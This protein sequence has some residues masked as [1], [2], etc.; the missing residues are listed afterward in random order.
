MKIYNFHYHLQLFTTQLNSFFKIRLIGYLFIAL[1][2]ALILG[3]TQKTYGHEE[4]ARTVVVSYSIYSF[5][6]LVCVNAQMISFHPLYYKPA[7][8]VYHHVRWQ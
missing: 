4:E 1:Y 7:V 8:F 2:L 3:E 5:S 6:Y